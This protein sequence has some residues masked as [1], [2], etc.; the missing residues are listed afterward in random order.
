MASRIGTHG[1]D[2]DGRGSHEGR[3]KYRKPLGTAGEEC[4]AVRLEAR[5]EP[6]YPGSVGS[7]PG[8]FHLN[9]ARPTSKDASRH[10]CG[11]G[12]ARRRSHSREIYQACAIIVTYARSASNAGGKPT[13]THL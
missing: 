13:R 3:C 11:F 5:A 2:L 12:G 9:C 8:L 7:A 6:E 4:R 1:S 10:V